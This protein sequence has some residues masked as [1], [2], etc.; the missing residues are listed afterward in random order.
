VVV[1]AL[2]FSKMLDALIA[3]EVTATEYGVA[4]RCGPLVYRVECAHRDAERLRALSLATA[5]RERHSLLE[6][7]SVNISVLVEL[8]DETVIVVGFSSTERRKLYRALRAVAGIGRRSALLV[9]DCGEVIDTLRAVVGKDSS[10]FQGVTGLGKAR[11]SAII[12]ELEKRY[13]EALPKALPLPV[14][15]WVEARDALLYSGLGPQAA[16]ELLRKAI[17]DLETLPRS[18]EALLTLAQTF[19]DA[20]AP[21]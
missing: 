14:L 18:A 4:A 8:A 10:Y 11:V 6:P 19:S 5:G 12:I 1:R 16:E 7:P 2:T 15:M 9:L 21:S 13:K 20:S 17:A 3:E